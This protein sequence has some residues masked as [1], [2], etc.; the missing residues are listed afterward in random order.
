MVRARAVSAR[1]GERGAGL[2]DK[3]HALASPQLSTTACVRCGG[4]AHAGNHV[5]VKQFIFLPNFGRCGVN[6]ACD[7][8]A[9]EFGLVRVPDSSAPQ[10]P[11]TCAGRLFV[12][13]P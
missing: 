2:P 13:V 3:K 11:G 12:F 10:P 6:L 9:R 8:N 5:F 1:S 7:K 4:G